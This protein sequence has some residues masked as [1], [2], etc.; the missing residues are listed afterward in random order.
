M[1]IFWQWSPTSISAMDCRKFI[2]EM[3]CMP[4]KTGNVCRLRQ[5]K[6]IA[7]MQCMPSKTGNV[8]RLRQAKFIAEMQCM[9]SKTYFLQCTALQGKR[10]GSENEIVLSIFF[11]CI[12]TRLHNTGVICSKNALAFDL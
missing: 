4:S 11:V 12:Y 5:A 1:T 7:E 2:A 3:Q 8:C 9:P 10:Q 6:F